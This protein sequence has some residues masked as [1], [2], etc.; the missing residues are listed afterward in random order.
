MNLR[1][2]PGIELRV[3]ARI[4][5]SWDSQGDFLA[6]ISFFLA[7][8][9]VSFVRRGAGH[10]PL[11]RAILVTLLT[12]RVTILR[13]NGCEGGGGRGESGRNVDEKH[14]E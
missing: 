4:A 12:Q 2:S 9:F 1:L 14:K 11:T 3:A 13:A 8:E 10:I 5:R 6:D 7:S